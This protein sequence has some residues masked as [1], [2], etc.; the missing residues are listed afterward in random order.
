MD[1][2]EY[3]TLNAAES[4]AVVVVCV[5]GSAKCLLLPLNNFYNKSLIQKPEL[6]PVRDRCSRTGITK[7]RSLMLC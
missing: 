6:G 3:G 5:N 7:P 1:F 2:A 4:A